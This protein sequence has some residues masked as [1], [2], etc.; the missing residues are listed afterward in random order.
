MS[1]EEREAYYAA[2]IGVLAVKLDIR[3]LQLSIG[4][5]HQWV[6]GPMLEPLEHLRMEDT[7]H[8][9]GDQAEVENYLTAYLGGTAGVFVRLLTRRCHLQRSQGDAALHMKFLRRTLACDDPEVDRAFA[10]AFALLSR[11]D[12]GDTEATVWRLWQRAV[13]LLRQSPQREQLDR[14]AKRLLEAGKMPGAEV[15]QLLQA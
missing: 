9:A 11:V 13:E 5:Q 8:C 14:L 4:Y 7:A 10:I 15:V 6:S 1:L 2:G 3:V 12:L